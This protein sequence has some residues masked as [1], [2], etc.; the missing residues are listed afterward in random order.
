MPSFSTSSE[1]NTRP[2]QPLKTSSM[3]V[4]SL[5]SSLVFLG[6]FFILA[7]IPR[8]SENAFLFGFTAQRFLL[9]LVALLLSISALALTYF[10][11][12][13]PVK[14]AALLNRL[15]LSMI[16]RA[17]SWLLVNLAWVVFFAI[18]SLFHPYESYFDRL[19]PLIVALGIV[20]AA[21][22]ILVWSQRH[23]PPRFQPIRQYFQR[24]PL[25]GWLVIPGLALALTVWS[26]FG[27]VADTPLWNVPG[28]PV[29]NLQFFLLLLLSLGGWLVFLNRKALPLPV[30]NL[31]IPF[32]IYLAAVILW[33]LTPLQHH[34]FITDLSAPSFQPFPVSDARVHDI[35]ALSILNGQGIYFYGYT[36]KPLAMILTAVFHLIAGR[37]YA[38]IQWLLVL[39]YALIP[40]F[41]Y[42]FAK[43]FLNPFIGILAAGALIFQQWN[44][45][46]LSAMISTV[47][48]KLL[49]TEA[50]TL[51][52]LVLIT[53][54]LFQFLKQPS[55]RIALALGGTI[56]AMGLIRL[57]PLLLLPVIGLTVLVY[58][59]KKWKLSLFSILAVAVGFAILF[60]PWLIFGTT[61]DGKPWIFIK[62]NDVI[63]NRIREHAPQS[64]LT[65]PEP[66]L[67][68]TA[69][70]GAQP[71]YQASGIN[72]LASQ[73]FLSGRLSSEPAKSYPALVTAHFWHNTAASFL[74]LPD[75]WQYEPIKSLASRDYWNDS[76]PW[77]G[78]FPAQQVVALFCNVGLVG[79]GLYF[80]WRLHRW[81][82]MVP[83]LL[84]FSYS[85][86]LAISLTSG[87][88]YIVPINWIIFFYYGLGWMFFT[89]W[90][91]R[92]LN[93]L[94]AESMISP[95]MPK[96]PNS[97]LDLRHLLGILLILAAIGSLVPIA[98]LL[99]PRVIASPFQTTPETYFESAGI[100]PL[101]NLQ[102]SLNQLVYPYWNESAKAFEY[103][104]ISATGYAGQNVIGRP[105]SLELS[106]W[107]HD[108]QLVLAGKDEQQK[109]Q[110]LLL[111]HPDG[112]VPFW[113]APSK[114]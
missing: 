109:V 22:W 11:Y 43:A 36:D 49:M 21:F 18:S 56:A 50:P 93:I 68:P 113:T 12:Q 3:L 70:P 8:E 33:G 30:V 60:G 57:N 51:L 89:F 26:R 90:L 25:V 1:P 64:S 42:R 29:S 61:P 10:I 73:P 23:C 100:Q 66:L 19:Q 80:A 24:Y 41:L 7:N 37:D 101:P 9:L 77:N 53:M 97:T 65:P 102:Y 47:N 108:G 107:P 40:V 20:T 104:L 105:D 74:A 78:S 111:I 17:L 35:G 99:L 69:M 46:R 39:V 13:K 86:A 55:L 79:L 59:G 96:Q 4:F 67:K 45:I 94:P 15:S 103:G 95:E 28:I 83:L 110:Q 14:M 98:N 75:G 85:L 58:F 27:L 81:L 34:F 71:L 38:L 106:N 87:G 63:E 91:L 76:L 62:I 2:G 5:F 92:W 6:A 54:W 114:R 44:A 31:A 72:H 16:V 112:L 52:G 88:R 84:F 82:G 32:L 48:I